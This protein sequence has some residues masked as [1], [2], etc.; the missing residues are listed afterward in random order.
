MEDRKEPSRGLGGSSEEMDPEGTGIPADR[1]AIAERFRLGER[2]RI[3]RG[4]EMT[5]EQAN[6]IYRRI[7]VARPDY[8]SWLLSKVPEPD[9]TLAVWRGMLLPIPY[10]IGN[11]VVG[12]VEAGTRE[13][14]QAYDRGAF[15]AILRS[16]CARIVDDRRREGRNEELRKEAS[17]GAH[18]NF[19][20]RM[21]QTSRELADANDRYKAGEISLDEWEELHVNTWAEFYI[22]DSS[23]S[24][25]QA[26][27]K[28]IEKMPE[29]RIRTLGS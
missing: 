27:A 23:L 28:A 12:E 14:P 15:G 3:E 10:E 26:R 9:K 24:P 2:S 11:G 7:F 29:R 22:E 8:R 25:D 6:D 5:E 4:C 13:L 19:N 18:G 20:T 1:R 16:W 21:K 17:R